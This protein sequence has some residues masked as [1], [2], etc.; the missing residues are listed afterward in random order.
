MNSLLAKLD[1]Q[2]FITEYEQFLAR[3]KP[4]FMEGDSNLHFKFIKKLTDYDFKAPPEVKNLD[5]ELMYLKKQ[6]RLRIYE[7]FEFV[8][9]VQYFIYLKKYLHEGIV[10]EWLDKI[11]I[12]PE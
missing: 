6:G 5:K 9:I 12:P 4:L 10:G 8:K 7:I 3:P 11:V 1:L 2:E